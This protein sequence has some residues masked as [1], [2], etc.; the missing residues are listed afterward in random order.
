MKMAQICNIIFTSTFSPLHHIILYWPPLPYPLR[1]WLL[2]ANFDIIN[3]Y[4]LFNNHHLRFVDGI[5][6]QKKE[7]GVEKAGNNCRKTTQGMK[8]SADGNHYYSMIIIIIIFSFYG[9]FMRINEQS[10][11]IKRNRIQEICN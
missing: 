4:Y 8:N 3:I 1:L 2:T 7:V 10:L 6:T 5:Y 11:S 9:S